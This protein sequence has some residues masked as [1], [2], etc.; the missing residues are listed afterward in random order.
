MEH[1]GRDVPGRHCRRSALSA[2]TIPPPAASQRAAARTLKH[3]LVAVRRRR[4]DLE[5]LE[6]LCGQQAR[7]GR[8]EELS[9]L[10]DQSFDAA[11]L[12][13][14]LHWIAD[15]PAALSGVFRVLKPGGRIG[16]NSADADH[17]HQSGALVR[18]CLLEEGLSE[19]ALASA[20]GNRYRVNARELAQL[21]SALG[22]T[23]A[24]VLRRRAHPGA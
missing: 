19:V 5:L 8:A 10:A 12:N 9:E 13:S 11:Y 24:D 20:L 7:L 3:Q 1:A 4:Q 16:V 6:G 18:E 21:E 23:L 22:E 14:V 2:H 17:A 15:K